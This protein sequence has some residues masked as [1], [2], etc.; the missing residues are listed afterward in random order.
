MKIHRRRW[1]L[2]QREL[3]RL[4]LGISTSA[5]ARYEAESCLPPFRVVVAM[6]LV[7]GPSAKELFP[8]VH[9]E[10]EE[11]VLRQAA[12]FSIVLEDVPGNR[13]EIKRELLKSISERVMA[14]SPSS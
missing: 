2:S 8:H 12:Q 14:N 6:G 5:L 11:Q 10:V 13:A 9:A 7:F 1:G 4:L 3:C